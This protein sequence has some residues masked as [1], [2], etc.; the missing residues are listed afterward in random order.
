M[1]P[2]GVSHI[3]KQDALPPCKQQPPSYFL[4]G[5]GGLS[6][7]D[8]LIHQYVTGEVQTGV[9]QLIPSCMVTGITVLLQP[10]D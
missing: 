7:W 10:E 4:K 2:M 6:E 1:L 8:L 3:T 9:Q 5:S